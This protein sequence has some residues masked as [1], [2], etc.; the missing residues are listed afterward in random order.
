[1]DCRSLN[2]QINS[3]SGIPEKGIMAT[4]SI[5]S[6]KGGCATTTLAL[7]LS[8]E[9]ALSHGYRVALL[10]SDL[11][12]HASLFGNK[13]KISGLTII[14]SIDEDNVLKTLRDA[15][16]TNDAVV[17]DLAGGSSTLALMALQ[18]SHLIVVPTQVSLPDSRDAMKTI[19]QINNAQELAR[20]PIA[21]AIIWTR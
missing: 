16:K 1:Y 4:I 14:G 12:Q 10:D 21:H 9:L 3:A 7:L 18:R 6:A 15:E 8:A 2:K 20:T 17:V 11:N 13:A 5:A 19:A